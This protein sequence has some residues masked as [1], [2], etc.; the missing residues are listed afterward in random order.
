MNT[1]YKAGFLFIGAVL[2][3]FLLQDVRADQEAPIPIA[4][5]KW[6]AASEGEASSKRMPGVHVHGGSHS[7]VGPNAP[8][9]IFR[10]SFVLEDAAVSTAEVAVCGLGH[11]E[12]SINGEKVGDH[13]LDPPWSDYAETCYYVRF[14]VAGHLKPGEN[15]LGVMLGH[16]MYHV[17]GGRYAKFTGSFG[18]PKL[19]LCLVVSQGDKQQIIASDRTWKTDDGPITFSCIYGGED[20]DA[21][22]EQRRWDSPGFDDSHWKPVKV[23]DGPGGKLRPALSPPVKVVRHLKAVS[24]AKTTDGRYEIDLGENLSAPGKTG[25]ARSGASHG[26]VDSPELRHGCTPAQDLSGHHRIATGKRIGSRHCPGVCAIQWWFLRISRV[27]QRMRAASVADPWLV[28]R[29]AYSGGA[30]PDH[31][32]IYGLPGR[33]TRCERA[34]ERG[35]G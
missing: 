26:T 35:A 23:V 12:L 15:V 30:I 7:P 22:R 5:A 13:F 17:P 4:Q 9:P 31:G 14:D 3:P 2:V 16:G 24:I 33:D 21:R 27:G 29:R 28:R 6:I 18:P 19:A 32:A 20:Y 11:F 34:R 1:R 8:L 25:L 10:K